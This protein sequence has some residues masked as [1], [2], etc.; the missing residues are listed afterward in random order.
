MILQSLFRRYENLAHKGKLPLKGWSNEKISFGLRLNEDGEIVQ[1]VDLRE[2]VT[3]GK[4]KT[5]MPR[6]ENVPERVKRAGT[7]S[8]PNFL[9]DNSSYILGVD[10]KGKPARSLQCFEATKEKHLA[11]L[12]DCASKTAVAIKNFFNNWIPSNAENCAVLKK[13]LEEIKN[14]GNLIFMYGDTLATE[15]EDIKNAWRISRVSD[16][17]S[18]DTKMQCLITGNLESIAR[19]HPSI[20]G[21]RDAQSSGANIVSFNKGNVAF[22]S[23]GNKDSQGLNAL[24]SEYAAFAYTTVLNSLLADKNHVKYFGDATVV[25]WAEQGD[26]EY[27]DAFDFFAF[28][29]DENKIDDRMLDDAMTAIKSGKHIDF[30][31]TV[32]DTKATFYILGLSP[33]AARISIRFFLQSTFGDVLKNIINHHKNMEIVAGRDNSRYVPIMKLK[34]SLV[35][36]KSRDK[37]L[38]PVL[39]GSILKSILSGGLYPESLFANAMMRIKSEQDYKD[40]RGRAF[41]KISH[42][43]CA[44]I[45]AYLMRN[46]G[47]VI[48]V[49]LDENERDTA[50]ILGRIFSVWEMI[51]KR[52]VEGDIN[53]T[54]KD[55]YFNAFCATPRNIFPVLSKLSQYHLKKLEGGQKI[56]YEKM[57]GELMGKLDPNS[58]PKI[59][60]LEEQG[61]F[62]LGY[63]HQTQKLFTKKEDNKD[64]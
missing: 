48:T 17:S 9:C 26:E 63:Y 43:R 44:I 16:D 28:G 18:D 8:N 40:D 19:I 34:D 4:K 45:K 5:L 25:Y 12:R 31:D 10:N 15:A 29:D 60:P 64:E 21:I 13:D 53:A 11:I 58:L 23:Y 55:R 24:V 38:S 59:L 14:G 7:G 30:K 42:T 51:Q 22:E 41:Y 27:Q 35:S 47:R 37:N 1:V 20:K 62:V 52:S 32:L 39:A 2:E 50:Y 49:A 56:Y 36:S 54:I 33:N 3:S 46:K 61:M 6:S 57:V